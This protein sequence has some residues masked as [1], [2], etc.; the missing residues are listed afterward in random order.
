MTPWKMLDDQRNLVV[1]NRNEKIKIHFIFP[2][3]KWIIICHVFKTGTFG[4]R[5]ATGM[6]KK[7][8]ERPKIA[9]TFKKIL[10]K[11]VAH[12]I[13]KGCNDENQNLGN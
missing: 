10:R 1:V 7:I 2:Q 9:R 8:S 6:F 12:H 4:R 5:D 13:K 11:A 3:Y